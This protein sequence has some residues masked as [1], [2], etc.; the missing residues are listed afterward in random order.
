MLGLLMAP[1]GAGAFTLIAGSPVEKPADPAFV[2]N[3]TVF[4][5][6]PP[7]S[8]TVKIGSVTTLSDSTIGRQN[9]ISGY[10]C[11]LWAENGP[12]LIY[13]LD[14]A[15]NLELQARLRTTDTEVDLD[16]FLLNDCDSDSC[17]VGANTEFTAELEAGIYYLV[18]D[19][20]SSAPFFEG[21]FDLELTARPPGLPATICEPG[22]AI[23]VVC[24]D[25][26]VV[27]EGET[28]FGQTDQVRIYDCGTF[29]KTSGE[30]W[31]AVTVA[32]E[33]EV[34]INTINV[35]PAFDT[36][37]WVFASCGPDAQC[38]DFVDANLAGSGESV[39]LINES[40]SATTWYVAVDA[41]RPPGSE[42]LGIF[43]IQ[44]QC[45]SNVPTAKTSLGGLKSLY[46]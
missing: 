34:V 28:L 21:A 1:I 42:A 35:Q 38:V 7:D 15:A 9:L 18:V 25:T 33:R 13:R 31:Y 22:G 46:R 36:C 39:T 2:Y 26:N 20:A 23:A 17:L 44:F 24:A 37:L 45:Q 41:V 10:P 5:C 14:V 16:L 4:D 11:A 43:D 30:I 3:R 19:G 40:G 6:N 29:P 32:V 27:R 8:L 12:E